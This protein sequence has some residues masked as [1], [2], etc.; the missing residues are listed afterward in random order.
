LL[1]FA[2]MM[3]VGHVQF[4]D[5]LVHSILFDAMFVFYSMRETVECN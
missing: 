5:Y 3:N 4:F 1:A 2:M